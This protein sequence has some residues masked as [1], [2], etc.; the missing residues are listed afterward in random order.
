MH[1]ENYI[2][3]SAHQ[4]LKL[5][6]MERLELPDDH[7]AMSV[8]IVQGF[9][10]DI[11]GSIANETALSENEI[12]HALHLPYWNKVKQRKHRRFNTAESD[13]IYALIEVITNAEALFGGDLS[14]AIH[15]LKSPPEP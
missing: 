14:E 3:I 13:R 2:P 1:H 4:P 15:W 9:R 12:L 6:L 5:T 10:F 11:V 8:L 7:L